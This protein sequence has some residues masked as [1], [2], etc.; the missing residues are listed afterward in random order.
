MDEGS[1]LVLVLMTCA[2][3]GEIGDQHRVDGLP[4]PL[5]VVSQPRLIPLRWPEG[6]GEPLAPVAREAAR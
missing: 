5:G 2:V 1:S 3:G 4:G 6:D